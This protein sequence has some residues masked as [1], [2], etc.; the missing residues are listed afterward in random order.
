VFV[1]LVRCLREVH[2]DAV[3][4]TMTGTNLLVTVAC[5]MLPRPFRLVLREA[6]SLQ[7]SRSRF[8]R[9]AMASVYPRADR[10]VAVSH[11]VAEDLRRLLLASDKL[12]VIENPIDVNRVRELAAQ[13][14]PKIPHACYMVTVGR[15]T[16]QKDQETLL[17]AYSAASI[18]R[19][20]A[21]VVVG[22]G[23]ERHKLEALC[24][25]LRV[26]GRVTFTGALT[27]P[28]PVIAGASLFVLSSRWEGYPNVLLEALALGVPVVATNCASGPREILQGGRVGALVDVADHM[29]LAR[30]MERVAPPDA[31][32]RSM[33]LNAHT[34]SKVAKEYLDVLLKRE[35]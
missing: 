17:R 8:L 23:E 11:G 28:Y 10:L 30:A 25:D 2:P 24:R 26:T 4:S 31:D 27:N 12:C 13:A 21:L 35:D 16:A 20:M 7:N 29:A 19:S 9:F 3:L 6:V 33:T 5:T 1:R 34:P 15:L 18:N 14:G 22:E 32:A